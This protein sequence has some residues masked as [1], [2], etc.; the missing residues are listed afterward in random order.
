MGCISTKEVL[1]SRQIDQNLQADHRVELN[2]V[3]LLILGMKFDFFD[4]TP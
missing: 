3:K 4:M 1:A 2:T